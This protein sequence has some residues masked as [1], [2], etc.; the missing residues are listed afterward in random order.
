MEEEQKGLNKVKKIAAVTL[1]TASMA[2]LASVYIFQEDDDIFEDA[3]TIKDIHR[4]WMEYNRKNHP[5]KNGNLTGEDL[6]KHMEKY[7]LVKDRY[8]ELK[9]SFY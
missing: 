9:K 4:V 6:L 5:D 3:D 1:L 2:F 7:H 8:D